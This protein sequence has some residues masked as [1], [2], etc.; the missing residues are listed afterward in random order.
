MAKKELLSTVIKILAVRTHY[1]TADGTERLS[2]VD[3]WRVQNPLSH[4]NKKEFDVTF[5]NKVVDEKGDIDLQWD[6]VGKNFDII[7]TSYIDSPKG[8]SYIKAIAHKHGIKHIMD[9]DDNFFDIDEFN[10]AY[11]RYFPGS[12]HLENATIILGDVDHLVCSTQNLAQTCMR[13][14]SKPIS[15]IENY[16]DPELFD[17]SKRVRPTG[18][19]NIG[20]MGSSTHY[21]DLMG[22]GALWALRRLVS[23][24]PDVTV[25]LVGSMYDEVGKMFTGYE[26]RVKQVGGKRDFI[27]YTSEVWPVFPFDIGI[28][29]LTDT[30][31]NACKSSIK[32]YEYALG[33]ILGIYS[34]VPPYIDKVVEGETGYFA[35]S[36]QEWYHKLNWVLDRPEEADVVRKTARQVVMENYTIGGH[37]DKVENLLRFV[38]NS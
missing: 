26:D 35:Q 14:R 36:E 4:I 10:P 11:L 13:Y 28:A 17:H 20:Y 24:R 15:V 18:G 19:K 38:A 30:P 23:E 16:I 34:W 29:P 3:S 27:E 12:P 31:F 5:V 7:Y 37:I 32:F 6:E 9:I 33:D 25:H 1:K 22:T 2:S 8:Y 21:S